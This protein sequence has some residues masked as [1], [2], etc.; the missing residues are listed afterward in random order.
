MCEIRYLTFGMV[1]HNVYRSDPAF[2]WGAPVGPAHGEVGD[3]CLETYKKSCETF[4]RHRLHDEHPRYPE[5][6]T[7]CGA[8]YD[9]RG[10]PQNALYY[11]LAAAVAKQKISGSEH[12]ETIK[13]R[14]TLRA[15][16]AKLGRD[17][18]VKSLDEG[19]ILKRVQNPHTERIFEIDT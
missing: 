4:E 14:K 19:A 3:K 10:E 7:C 15:T 11:R 6:L 5:S 12:A 8:Q 2:V 13:F 1:L 17:D 9:D 16:L 18:D